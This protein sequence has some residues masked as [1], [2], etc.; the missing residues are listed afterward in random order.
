[1]AEMEWTRGASSA[2]AREMPA[3]LQG[4]ANR[5]LDWEDILTL[6]L[7]A[8][9]IMS[10]SVTLESGGWS[11]DMPA[12][13]LV[14]LLG[15]ITALILTRLHLSS[16]LSWPAT[17]GVG[18]LVVFWQTLLMVG[19]GSP[20]QRIDAIYYRFEAWF[21]AAFVNTNI[22]NNDPLPLHVLTL[23]VTWLGVTFFAWGVFRWHNAWLGLIPG[24]L[25]LFLD[26]AYVGDE[27]SG[28]VLL[29]VLFGFLLIMRT[30]LTSKISRWRADGTTYPSLISLTFLN[31]TAWAM[32]A[33]IS[34]AWIAPVGPFTTP[35]PVTTLVERFHELG[36]NFVRIAGP[37][38]VKKVVPV[39]NYSG[40]LP[41]QGS[42]KLGSRE[43]LE[44]QVQDD[45]L[46]GPFVLRGATYAQYG[47]GGW[48]AGQQDS[49][50]LS[51]VAKDQVLAAVETG[52]LPGKI[53]PIQIEVQ[54]KSVVGNVLFTIGRPIST[55]P[56]VTARIPTAS[57]ISIQPRLPGD[58]RELSD[59]AILRD[60]VPDRY[61]GVQVERSG[62]GR[63]ENVLV[64]DTEDQPVMDT[65]ALQPNGR[66][67]KGQTYN[68][69]GF[70]P[71]ATP[72]ELRG[73][74]T[75]YPGWVYQYLQ[76]PND[77]PPE[78]GGMADQIVMQ[79]AGPGEGEGD[80][81][82]LNAESVPAYDKAKALEGYLRGFPLDYRIPDT[83]PGR[84]TVDYFLFELQRGYFDYHASAMV[85]MLRTLG[86][87]AR[88]GVGFVV[89][90]GDLDREKQTY[91]VRDRHTYSWAEVYFPEHGWVTFNPSPD[92]P[93]DLT[94]KTREVPISDD[95]IDPRIL[96]EIPVG[97]DPIFDIPAGV[98][99]GSGSQ[100]VTTSPQGGYDP[101]F[102]IAVTAVAAMLIG[103]IALGW[104]RSVSGLPF[105][106][107]HWE[108]LV[109]L[110][111]LAGYPP[112]AGQTPV[113]FA[114]A[115]Q[116]TNRGLRGVSV[117]AAAY[118]RS[119]FAHRDT[120]EEERERIRELWPHL[121]GALLG[122][123]VSR[124]FRR[125]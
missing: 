28:A 79:Q 77:L 44:V 39:H 101:L 110:S 16:F 125:R 86:V 121:R 21:D 63:V 91:V 4:F 40:V 70:L 41:F 76:L 57:L 27:L 8:G 123:T 56:Q 9:A 1:M 107:Q 17:I 42:I 10:V 106:Q 36:V 99:G 124:L 60:Y 38:H 15:A 3:W 7:T 85:V 80:V 35:G 22:V 68:I 47:S 52:E 58:G 81:I 89:D 73:A 29:Y 30:N 87:P 118:C 84:D 37:L 75:D 32:L 64:F 23:T 34:V 92:R 55:N 54:R 53:V 19:P 114:R 119:R 122:A 31:F 11:R 105:A 66:I 62:R 69:T 74:G 108:K 5:F 6:A 83:P 65:V 24:S 45:T 59:I 33:V 71:E 120:T 113:E 25:A 98:P 117:L 78:I 72:E 46:E 104:Q 103:A 115:L 88:L 95:T 50:T 100:T 116:R 109:R 49:V 112:Q 18:A 82:F 51:N 90:E 97:A 12:I 111:S 67:K 14:A 43:I 2:P 93:A 48:E 94:P 61:I 13:T 20:E 102:A 26:L 96:E